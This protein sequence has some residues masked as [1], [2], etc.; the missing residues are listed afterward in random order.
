MTMGR[1]AMIPTPHKVPLLSPIDDKYLAMG[2]DTFQPVETISPNQFLD[3]N[4]RLIGILGK[5]LS[6]IYHSTEPGAKV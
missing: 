6:T 5:I 2:N 1:L 3:E 4:M